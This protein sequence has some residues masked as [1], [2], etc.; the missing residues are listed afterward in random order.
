[1]LTTICSFITTTHCTAF[2]PDNLLY[3]ACRN[4]NPYEALHSFGLAFFLRDVSLE[5]RKMLLSGKEYVCSSL[6]KA[7]ML[8]E[9][10]KGS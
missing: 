6:N 8:P 9:L 7:E 4:H 2:H 3:V 5:T 10:L 1:M